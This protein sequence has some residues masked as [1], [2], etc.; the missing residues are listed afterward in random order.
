[1][2]HAVV[3]RRDRLSTRIGKTAAQQLADFFPRRIRSL[4]SVWRHCWIFCLR[5]RL[6]AA[7]APP[8]VLQCDRAGTRDTGPLFPD[9]RSSRKPARR[10]IGGGRGIE[11]SHNQRGGSVT[12][13]LPA[14]LLLVLAG[15]N[16]DQD[17]QARYNPL[18]P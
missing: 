10:N 11:S 7:L 1:M 13:F 12:R 16:E 17:A 2:A 8:S 9:L 18:A 5:K 3:Q 14:F 4:H 6:Q 15:C